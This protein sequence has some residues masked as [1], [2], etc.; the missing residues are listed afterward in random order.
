MH[1][2][3]LMFSATKDCKYLLCFHYISQRLKYYVAGTAHC[4]IAV[5]GGNWKLQKE[6]KKPCNVLN[7]SQMMVAKLSIY[8]SH[9]I[10]VTVSFIISHFTMC[11]YSFM[12]ICRL[13]PDLKSRYLNTQMILL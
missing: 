13:S 5:R 9:F 6:P 7:F 3:V 4:S 8:M 2:F 1:S 12:S 11:T 10:L